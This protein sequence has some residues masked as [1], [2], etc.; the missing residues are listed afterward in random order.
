MSE[1]LNSITWEVDDDGNVV[2][3]VKQNKL[4]LRMSVDQADELASGLYSAIAGSSKKLRNSRG[5]SDADNLSGKVTFADGDTICEHG[6]RVRSCDVC[7]AFKRGQAK[8]R[9]DGAIVM[10]ERYDGLFA[11]PGVFIDCTCSENL[12]DTCAYHEKGD[13]TPARVVAAMGEPNA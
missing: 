2:I 10:E 11:H 4:I 13:I 7:Q 6:Q 5:F 8:G 3:T 1:Q 12:E 9:L